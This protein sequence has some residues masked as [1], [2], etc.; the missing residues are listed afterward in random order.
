MGNELPTCKQ[1]RHE[2]ARFLCEE[3]VEKDSAVMI[4]I[5][6]MAG[7]GKSTLAMKLCY[8]LLGKDWDKVLR[9]IVFNPFDLKKK[10][11]YALEHNTVYRCIIWDDSG[12]WWE[13]VKRYPYD[14]FSLSLVGHVETM[15][16][17]VKI[18]INTM[19][20]EKHLPRAVLNN[21][22]LY[23]YKIRVRKL[24][25]DKKKEAWFSRATVYRRLET[26]DE[27][28]YWDRSN[29]VAF[30]FQL[31]KPGHPVYEKYAEMRRSYVEFYNTFMEE[32]KRVGKLSQVA[33]IM[34]IKGKI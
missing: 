18:F 28:W 3:V 25:Y 26:Y 7:D 6:G 12:P 11:D 14:P 24:F 31:F 20:T 4:V 13:L 33:K 16:T 8:H 27:K 19:L 32:A 29:P 9:S 23:R 2:L 17:W 15:R 1:V 22:F 30:N 21:G 10:I 5:E 34:E